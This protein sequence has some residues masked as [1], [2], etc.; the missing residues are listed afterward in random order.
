MKKSI[1]TCLRCL[2]LFTFSD[3]KTIVVPST[4]FGLTI[5]TAASRFDYQQDPITTIIIYRMPST[6]AWVWLNLLPFAINNQKGADA[7]E[8]DK[9]N[10]PWRPLPSGQLTASQAES[11]MLRFYAV[12]ILQS[13]F[14]SGALKQTMGL[15]VFGAWYNNCNGAD[16]NPVVRNAIN[17]LGY[18]CFIS[19][20]S[21]V[22]LDRPIT[23]SDRNTLSEW[24]AIVAAIVF[25][26]VHIQDMPDQNG[27]AIRS[28]RTLPL[29]IGDTASRWT[30]CVCMVIWGFAC[31]LFW[32]SSL[33]AWVLSAV[34]SGTVGI[35][36]VR[37]RGLK[38]DERTFFVWNIWMAS[39]YILPLSS[40]R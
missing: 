5:A 40:L 2:W 21:E 39:V 37:W 35:R 7:I 29:V 8:E 19:G 20:A 11:W 13:A 24:L 36:M 25:T 32:Q 17:A 14:F 23:L 33:Y 15:V 16:V 10:K 28:R 3:L 31:P 1:F 12:A 27:D 18:V 4:I 26:T 34:L 30:I 38:H 22:A 9:I 6:V